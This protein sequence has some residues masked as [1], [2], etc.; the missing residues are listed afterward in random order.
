MKTL[1]FLTLAVFAVFL[2]GCYT[3][4]AIEERRPERTYTY[5]SYGDEEYTESDT[6]YYDEE[7]ASQ[8]EVKNIY[9]LP[10][11]RRYLWHY[12]PSTSIVIGSG[13]YF[14]YWLWDTWYPRWWYWDPWYPPVAYYPFWYYHP[15][16]YY[17]GG[18]HWDN[19]NNPKTYKYR[20]NN[21]SRI[22]NNDG[23]RGSSYTTRD[24][25]K[26]YDRNRPATREGVGA[27]ES[28]GTREA[29][30]TRE[31]EVNRN[32]RVSTQG[33]TGVTREENKGTVRD[34]NR[35][36]DPGNTGRTPEVRPRQRENDRE[37]ARERKPVYV[38]RERKKDT[39][40]KAPARSNESERR[41][42]VPNDDNSGRRS[43]PPSYNPPSNNGGSRQSTPPSRSGGSSS[44]GNR[45][46][47]SNDSPRRSR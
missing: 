23:G 14:D 17:Y 45:G 32:G 38:P 43:T 42:V 9:I 29:I 25:I 8:G 34:G 3:Q 12:Y 18:Y 13:Y 40:K 46:S 15:N 36:K 47:G 19:Y 2:S 21:I 31:S 11:Y 6:I 37:P 33:R 35:T 30:S 41:R 7:E 1:R 44:G 27:R 20:D 28:I 26:A 39:E 4:L 24:A 16:Y 22:R 5:E 10:G